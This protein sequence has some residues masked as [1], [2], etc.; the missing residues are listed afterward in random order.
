[1]SGCLIE[2]IPLDAVYLEGPPHGFNML[3]VKEKSLL[4][5]SVFRVCR[6]K[7]PKLLLYKSPSLHH[8]TEWLTR[9]PA[10]LSEG[11]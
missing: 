2:L 9:L 3:A 5:P 11:D 8:P 10:W 7:S 1:M 4:D 6:N